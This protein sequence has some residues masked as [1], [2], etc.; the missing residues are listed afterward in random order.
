MKLVAVVIA[1]LYVLWPIDLV[2][3]LIPVIGWLD[4]VI[5]LIVG[6]SVALKG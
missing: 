3:D 2:P 6:F 1:L 5:A 4:D